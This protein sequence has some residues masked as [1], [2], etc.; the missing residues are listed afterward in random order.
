[1]K[2]IKYLLMSMMAIFSISLAPV[3]VLAGSSTDAVCD[4]VATTSTTSNCSTGTD[5]VQKVIKLAIQIFQMIV[6]IIAVF[7]FITAGLN[8]VTSAG[9][10]AKTKTAKDRILYG[11]IGLVVVALAQV[12]VSFVLNRVSAT[13]GL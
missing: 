9:D 12:I 4:G 5:A 3:A 11:A 7:M 13:T 8:Y 6:G 2:K 1:M 10:G